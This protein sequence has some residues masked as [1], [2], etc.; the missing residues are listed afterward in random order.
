MR[1]FQNSCNILLVCAASMAMLSACASNEATGRNQ[2]TGLMPASSEANVGADEN[3]KVIKQYGVV[4][5]T[6]LKAYVSRVGA[7]IA[8]QSERKDVTYTFTVLDSPV[9][10]AFALPGGYIYITRGLLA[11]MNDEAQL[12]GVLAHEMGH[13]TARHSAE[14]YSQQVVGSLGVNVLGAVLGGGASSQAL[15]LGAN[16]YFSQYSQGQ[17]YEA[18]KLGVRYLTQA[19]YDPTAVSRFLAV[20]QGSDSLAAQETGGGKSSM[21]SLFSSHPPTPERVQRSAALAQE[22]RVSGGSI[23]REAFLQAVHGMTY[24]SSPKEGFVKNGQFIH[25]DLGFVF[26]VPQGFKVNNTP[27]QIQVVGA[28]GKTGLVF[29]SAQKPSGQDIGVFLA[30][31]GQGKIDPRAVES[32]RVAGRPA[33][34][35]A[36]QG[37]VNNT[38]ATLRLVAVDW[39]GTQVYKFA[40][41]LPAGTPASVEGALRDAAYSLRDVSAAERNAVTPQRV[42]LY[43][44]SANDTVESLAA[45][46]GLSPARFRLLNGLGDAERLTAGQRYKIVS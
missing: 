34:T 37:S 43:Q 17:E 4:N 29:D 26:N 8:A 25:P 45:K 36:V 23:G 1:V 32:T 16:L 39:N 24:G 33:A 20:L 41:I 5:D 38:P 11:L 6:A 14:R 2:F 18:D 31:F 46:S 3:A 15:G 42:L 44:A 13:V 35:A 40:V 21:P 9:E 30:Q 12:A 27:Q 28:D 19:G 7:K 22:T 10:N